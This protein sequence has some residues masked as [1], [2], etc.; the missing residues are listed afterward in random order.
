[1]NR[2]PRVIACLLLVFPALCVSAAPEPPLFSTKAP[3]KAVLTAPVHQA[4]SQ[5]KQEKRL[6]LEGK[7]SYKGDADSV[8]LPVKIRTRGNY[9]REVCKLPPLQLNFRK[10]ELEDT[11][12]ASQNKLKMVSPCKTGD[13]YQQLIYLEYLVYQFYALVSEHH[14]KTR[15]VEVSYVDTE[16]GKSWNSTNFLIESEKALLERLGMEPVEAESTQRS[17]MNLRE[18]ALLEVFQLM[19]GNVD[20]S[21]L[22]SP[23]GKS[24]CHNVVPIAPDETFTGLIPIAY[25]FD[26]S[27]IINAPYATVPSSVP[28]TRVTQRY[29][30]GW[31]KQEQRYREAISRLNTVREEAD[32]IFS[33]SELLSGKY[34]KNAV[35]YLERSYKL[36][37]DEDFVQEMILGRCR[38]E[39]IKG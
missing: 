34:R 30:T 8:A 15:L 21:S 33:D 24:C 32:A 28:I 25:D 7:W 23:P 29:F 3:F 17:A 14:F 22:K 1:M 39:V 4:Y 37:N 19:I 38:G 10:N 5:K 2:S 18:T 36:I 27:G 13:K 6:Y 9:R 26:S 31:C 20:Y 16:K 12:F 35:E 11:L